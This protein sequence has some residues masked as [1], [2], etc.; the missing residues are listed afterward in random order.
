[1][2]KESSPQTK[3]Y[4]MIE[5]SCD[6]KACSPCTYPNCQRYARHLPKSKKLS[7]SMKSKATKD[8]KV[9]EA[10]ADEAKKDSQAVNRYILTELSC[11]EAKCSPCTYPNCQRYARSNK[12]VK[13]PKSSPVVSVT[14]LKGGEKLKKLYLVDST[15]DGPDKT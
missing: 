4:L 10:L 12:K 5:L 7:E 14:E 13:I 3:R 15:I 2:E 1:M 8:R 9:G 6:Q 11:S